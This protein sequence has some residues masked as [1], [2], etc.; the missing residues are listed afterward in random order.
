MV[1]LLS[2]HPCLSQHSPVPLSLDALVSTFCLFVCRTFTFP[3][4]VNN[5]VT[6]KG[7]WKS[8]EPHLDA[9][10]KTQ[11]T[12]TDIDINRCTMQLSHVQSGWKLKNRSFLCHPMSEVGAVFMQTSRAK[13]HPDISFCMPTMWPTL[14]PAYISNVR[15]TSLIYRPPSSLHPPSLHPNP[16]NDTGPGKRERRAGDRHEMWHEM[17]K[18]SPTDTHIVS[19]TQ[20]PQTSSQA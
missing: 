12:L 18:R 17:Q 19:S 16:I 13:N 20:T 5:C 1:Y 6:T 3:S 9:Q 10:F 8:T 15:Q 4:V 11:H 7:G 14:P 2:V